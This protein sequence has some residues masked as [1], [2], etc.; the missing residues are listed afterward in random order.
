[1][2]LS[3]CG[4]V[5]YNPAESNGIVGATLRH[6]KLF[7]LV[8]LCAV[9][10]TPAAWASKPEDPLEPVNRITFT[11]N[12]YVDRYFLKPV[13][14]GYRKV[15]P[16][17]AEEGIS[18][19]FDNLGEPWNIVNNLLQGK[20]K[21]AG[22][23]SLRLLVNTTVG[24]FGFIDIGSRIGLE[25]HDEDLGQTLGVWGVGSGPYL[26]LP[27]LGPSTVRDGI[28]RVPQSML[29]PREEIDHDR[30]RYETLALDIVSIRASLL[31]RERIIAGDRYSFIRDAYLQNREFK[32]NDGQQSGDPFADDDFDDEFLFDEE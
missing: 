28:A 22:S 4:K 7:S 24:L 20:P 5:A 32:V 16:D 15:T 9:L 14:K 25:E 2:T 23:D 11:F 17:F 26:V 1:M 19:F 13:A 21:D 6:F 10:S 18:N 30:T 8:A 12:D 27:L 3:W 29:S 31:E